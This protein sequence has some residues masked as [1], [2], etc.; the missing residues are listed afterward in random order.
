[1][2]DIQPLNISVTRAPINGHMY[3]VYDYQSYVEN[4]ELVKAEKSAVIIER[5]GKKYY[6][7]YKGE[8][9][10]QI[11]PGIY[12]A[13]AVDF[14][15]YPEEAIEESYMPKD[16]INYSNTDSAKEILNKQKMINKL[17]EPWI[18]N[19]DNITKFNIH[20]DDQPE[21][22]GLKMAMNAKEMDF[23]KY[24]NRFGDNFPN[25]KR[26]M[27]NHKATLNIIERFAEKCDFDVLLTFRDKRPNVPNPM[28]KEITVSLTDTV[29][30][31]E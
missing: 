30:D 9:E 1:M 21:M 16:I 14:V 10:S 6:M 27:K 25:D 22:V 23:D 12:D 20:P 7:P 13:G 19:P 18:T 2:M 11:S 31:S 28:G 29:F 8:Y 26:Q 17:S 5:D 3:Y 4:Q 24:A 15:I